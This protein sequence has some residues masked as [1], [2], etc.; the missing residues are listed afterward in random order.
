M[1]THN[2][3]VLLFPAALNAGVLGLWLGARYRGKPSSLPALNTPTFLRQWLLYQGLVWLLWAPWF[4]PFVVQ[5]GVVAEEFWLPSPSPIIVWQA[6]HNFNLAFLPL[7]LPLVRFW[8]LVF[9]ACALAAVYVYRRKPARVVLLSRFSYCRQYLG[10]L[11]SI[12][13]PVFYDQ[14]LIW[15]TLPYFILIGA[16][17]G[18]LVVPAQDRET[19]SGSRVDAGGRDD[20]VPWRARGRV[21]QIGAVALIVSLSSIAVW[22]YQVQWVKEEWDKAAAHVAEQADPGDLIL[23]NASWVQLPFD[24][25]FRRHGVAAELRGLPADLFD[26]GVLEP[27]MAEEYLP[28]LRR[29]ADGRDR[30]WLVYSHEKY[31]D[32]DRLIPAELRHMMEEVEVQEF[33]GLKVM[34]FDIE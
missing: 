18:G 26:L 15:V 16:G 11:L 8:D 25:Y 4:V 1:L 27:R 21:V 28:E 9:W 6:F 29:L 2:T 3:A 31:T 33:I 30:I 10:L 32:P 17:I 23:F 14:T 34:R 13:R 24:Y 7:W 22:A 20:K 12:R 19:G 5:V